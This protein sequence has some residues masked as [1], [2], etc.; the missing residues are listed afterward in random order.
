MFLGL[1]F[2]VA[3]FSLQGKEVSAPKDRI[4]SVSKVL[5]TS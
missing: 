2:I 5:Y 1:I 4:E 3:I